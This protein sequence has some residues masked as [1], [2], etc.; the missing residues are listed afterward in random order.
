MGNLILQTTCLLKAYTI[1]QKK[2]K[3]LNSKKEP[4]SVQTLTSV[5]FEYSNST[6]ILGIRDLYDFVKF[7]GFLEIWWDKL[8]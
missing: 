8:W 4:L 6:D 3:P 5:C 7:L 2:F 1:M